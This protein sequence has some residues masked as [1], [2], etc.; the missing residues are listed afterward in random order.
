[1]V[2]LNHDY[3]SRIVEKSHSGFRR[4][5]SGSA[6]PRFSDA[7]VGLRFYD[8]KVGKWTTMDPLGVD[9]GL[10]AYSFCTS[11]PINSVDPF[12]LD[13]DGPGFWDWLQ[14]ILDTGG[15]FEPTPFCDLTSATISGFRGKW[16]DAGWSLLGV[17][18]YIGD[19]G[20]VGKYGCKAKKY[21]DKC[22]SLDNAIDNL[23]TISKTQD[24][25]RKGKT[26][27]KIIDSTQSSQD[28]VKNML[29]RIKHLS[30]VQ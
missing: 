9:A 6:Y 11:D 29:R 13:D 15:T 24:M 8:N 19:V 3:V 26:T 5:T 22:K 14:G 10:N 2:T 4:P 17:V 16:G 7:R 18:P 25:I 30:D 21:A 27:E 12:G 20:K 23:K 28:I 1:M